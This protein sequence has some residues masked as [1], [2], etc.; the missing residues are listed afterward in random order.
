MFSGARG[1]LQS[2]HNHSITRSQ[3]EE[4]ADCRWWPMPKQGVLDRNT[5]IGD[6]MASRNCQNIELSS[7]NDPTWVADWV[8]SASGV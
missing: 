2:L 3:Q 7:S 6:V 1:M 4:M 8:S 5:I